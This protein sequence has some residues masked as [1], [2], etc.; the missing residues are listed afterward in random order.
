MSSRTEG[1]SVNLGE[2]KANL[3]FV[4]F[5]PSNGVA[6]EP[7]PAYIT[8]EMAISGR[9]QNYRIEVLDKIELERVSADRHP[10]YF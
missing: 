5:D 3:A 2:S 8:F 4:W 1:D 6:V 10:E 9:A 7:D